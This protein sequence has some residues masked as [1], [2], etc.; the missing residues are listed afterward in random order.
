MKQLISKAVFIISILV[1][2]MSNLHAQNQKQLWGLAFGGQNDAG[3]I[4]KTDGSGNNEMVKYDFADPGGN[5]YGS[6]MRASNGNLYGMT[7]YGGANNVGSLF[8]YDPR[9][10]SFTI[11]YDFDLLDGRYP[12][13][14]L[15]QASDGM[16]YGMATEGGNSTSNDNGVIFKFNPQTDTYTKLFDFDGATSGSVPY[17]ALMQAS[18]GMLYGMTSLGGVNDMGVLFQFNPV[19][20]TFA[21]KVDFDGTPKG[22][23]PYGSLMQATDGKLYGMTRFGGLNGYGVIF[24]FDPQNNN[25]TNM[26]DF[27]MVT[28]GGLPEGSLV[29]ATDGKFYGLT[30]EGGLHS[31][32]I[33]FQF[34]STNSAMIDKF[35]FDDSP[36]GSA[37]DGS[38]IQAYDG[39]LYGMTNMGGAVGGP[40]DQG[41]IFQFNPTT[42]TF[43]K[44]LDF[45]GTNGRNPQYTNL[46]EIPVTIATS[47]V[48]LI[49]CVGSS[50]SVSFT[51]EGAYDAGN[52]FTAQLSDATGSFASPITI[53]SISSAFVGSINAVIPANT[54]P[55]TAYRIRVVGSNPVVTGSDNG[56]NITIN[57]LPNVNTTVSGATITVN[58][59]GA[60]YQWLN[61]N[62]GNTVIPGETHQS[63]TPTANG[64]YA[65]IV[66]MNGNGCS[67]TSNC[68]TIANVGLDELETKD[69]FAVYP[70]PAADNITI[71]LPEK[72]TIE[73]RTIEGQI[74]KTVDYEGK[75]LEISL[76]GL[77]SGVYIISAKTNNAIVTKTLIKH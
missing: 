29:Q 9:T 54:T 8:Q 28:N 49:N 36:N 13:G 58:Q 57:A 1:Y 71:S 5:P 7:Y 50:L 19:N 52:V 53:G 26:L 41:I 61:C 68:V 55:G 20:N 30:K 46:I 48:G 75:T 60:T 72:A 14:S 34:N 65:V 31:V 18:D 51:I 64:S 35:D 37:P 47:P 2:L 10:W 63:Y 22:Q 74:V 76:S 62:T 11:K 66:T 77:T 25:F 32:G 42:S 45:N 43:T 39:N 40:V 3:I 15:M 24:K 38:L 21:K 69:H 27:D 4:F 6:L 59:A 33:L 44:K 16:L 12:Q 17:G 70:N 67:A 23:N 56:S 73:I